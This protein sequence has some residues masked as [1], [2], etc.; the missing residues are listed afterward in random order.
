MVIV[1]G[2]KW[3]S[4]EDLDEREAAEVIELPENSD[5]LIIIKERGEK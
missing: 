5:D 1:N 3:E 4:P 2:E